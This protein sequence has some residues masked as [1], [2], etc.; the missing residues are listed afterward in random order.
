MLSLVEITN[1][2]VTSAFAAYIWADLINCWRR[3]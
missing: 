2:C 1:M 3:P